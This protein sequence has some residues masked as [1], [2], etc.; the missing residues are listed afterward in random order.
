MVGPAH[1]VNGMQRC[2]QGCYAKLSK[3]AG[4]TYEHLS[5]AWDM[6]GTW[7][8]RAVQ[9]ALH[10]TEPTLLSKKEIDD[11]TKD[12]KDNWN[13]WTP[14]KTQRKMDQL[15]QQIKL[16]KERKLNLSR[17]LYSEWSPTKPENIAWLKERWAVK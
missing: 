17:L 13:R 2:T 3:I 9:T 1:R 6:S 15:T 14:Q 12:L 7:A 10:W 11:L 5:D 8:Y 16:H 4:R